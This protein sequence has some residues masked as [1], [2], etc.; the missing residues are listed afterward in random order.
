M[1]A[2]NGGRVGFFR[3]FFS[4]L[5]VTL[6]QA[7]VATFR[8]KPVTV[9]Y[10]Y[11]RLELPKAFRGQHSIDWEKCIGCELCAKVCS[12]GAIVSA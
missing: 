9:L 2:G 8:R 5:W 10:P 6:K 12:R 4:P 1:S 7:L 3:G 11:E